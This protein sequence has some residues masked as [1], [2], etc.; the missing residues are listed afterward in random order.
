MG[1]SGSWAS[2]PREELRTELGLPAG[3]SP[4]LRAGPV[5]GSKRGVL[6]LA[7]LGLA[8]CG[9]ACECREAFCGRFT[10]IGEGLLCGSPRRIA[11]KRGSPCF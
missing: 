1:F 5:G 8:L 7:G 6:W 2:R 4:G 10:L 11:K 9:R 3:S